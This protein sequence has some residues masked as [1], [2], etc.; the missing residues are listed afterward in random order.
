M[1][2]YLTGNRAYWLYRTHRSSIVCIL[3]SIT[4][5]VKA[6]YLYKSGSST[7]FLSNWPNISLQFPPAFSSV[8]IH[9]LASSHWPT[10]RL[11]CRNLYRSRD[12]REASPVDGLSNNK[13]M[14][15][16]EPAIYHFISQNI[17]PKCFS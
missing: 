11:L 7:I 6:K 2:A 14:V 12:E 3:N 10:R 8:P 17:A 9:A 5:H 4:K 13:S 1:L 15:S 16:N